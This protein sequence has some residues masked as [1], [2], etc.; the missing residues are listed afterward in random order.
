MASL[1]L[2]RDLFYLAVCG[3]GF[4]AGCVIC[5]LT[6]RLSS[7]QRNLTISGAILWIAWMLV[8]LTL[9]VVFSKGDVFFHRDF[10]IVGGGIFVL[11]A[12]SW[13]FP[14]Q[15]GL[16]FIIIAGFF[17]VAFAFFFLRFPSANTLDPLVFRTDKS[18]NVALRIMRLSNSESSAEFTTFQLSNMEDPLVIDICEFHI[19][20][21]LPLSGGQV[22]SAP[23][24]IV[25]NGTTVF[26]NPMISRIPFFDTFKDEM[27]KSIISVKR[28]QR[29]YQ[30]EDL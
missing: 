14:K 27:R 6:S 23:S 28:A 10:Y 2:S 17:I 7:K 20:E 13:R 21:A 19:A 29:N 18:N 1:F 30:I 5:L 8:F 11:A 3:L 16:P 25:Q 26:I 9:A 22:R 15:I 12:V 4:S 24:K